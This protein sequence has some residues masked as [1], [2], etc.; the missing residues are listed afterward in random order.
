MATETGAKDL[1]KKALDDLSPSPRMREPPPQ[2]GE[3]LKAD[4]GYPQKFIDDYN[5]FQAAYKDQRDENPGYWDYAQG[6][7]SQV[8]T[9][10]DHRRQV[11]QDTLRGSA[12][13]KL[14]KPFERAPGDHEFR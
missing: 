14:T 11:H 6:W 7:W 4:S 2:P 1:Q 9:L 3:A 10:V 13:D 12:L 5:A 8:R